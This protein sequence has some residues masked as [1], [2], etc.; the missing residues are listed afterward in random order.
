MNSRG[1][2]L[3]LISENNLFQNQKALIQ[4][5]NCW[6]FGVCRASI[7]FWHGESLF[8]TCMAIKGI[9]NFLVRLRRDSGDSHIFHLKNCNFDGPI[10]LQE[11]PSI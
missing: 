6:L 4:D 9:G 5:R 11:N 1:I 10:V 7:F 3:E 2:K 8:K